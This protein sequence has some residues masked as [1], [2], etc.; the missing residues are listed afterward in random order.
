MEVVFINVLFRRSARASARLEG[1]VRD[2][3]RSFP[4]FS[5]LVPPAVRKVA[6]VT[7]RKPNTDGRYGS[8]KFNEA[9][10]VWASC[11]HPLR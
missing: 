4:W 5:A 8:T 6:S 9:I 2:V 3:F 11:S 1:V 10:R 7:P